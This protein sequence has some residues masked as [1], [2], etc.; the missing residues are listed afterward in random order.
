MFA[1]LGLA[2]TQ[3]QAGM[4]RQIGMTTV[5]SY[6]RSP[7]RADWAKAL[8]AALN[9]NND[10]VIRIDWDSFRT[11]TIL[12]AAIYLAAYRAGLPVKLDESLADLDSELNSTLSNILLL[13]TA[14]LEAAREAGKALCVSVEFLV[15]LRNGTVRA[16]CVAA[17][18]HL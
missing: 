18:V 13:K 11:T 12:D 7:D 14:L 10:A 16:L 8:V 3:R 1:P 5:N 9:T 4:K 15:E 2:N 6:M 17:C